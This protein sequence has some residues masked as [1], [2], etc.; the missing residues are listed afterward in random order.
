MGTVNPV[1]VNPN[2]PRIIRS[3]VGRSSRDRNATEKRYA[4]IIALWNEGKSKEEI[5]AAVKIQPA[6]VHIILREIWKHQN[7]KEE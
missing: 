1:V 4:E 7:P 3:P 5:G 6:R 2:L